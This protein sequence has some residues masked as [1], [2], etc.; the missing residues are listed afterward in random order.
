MS[1]KLCRVQPLLLILL[2]GVTWVSSTPDVGGLNLNT[3]HILGGDR[4]RDV[5]R[6]E[7]DRGLPCARI[8][9]IDA[10][11]DQA[12]ADLGVAHETLRRTD[13]ATRDRECTQEE[14]EAE[15]VRK[16]KEAEIAKAVAEEAAKK[17]AAGR[18]FGKKGKSRSCKGWRRRLRRCRKMMKA[19]DADGETPEEG[20]APD[21]AAPAS[22]KGKG[23][24][25]GGKK[26]KKGDAEA[27]EAGADAGAENAAA[28]AGEAAAAGAAADENAE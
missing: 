1:P 20:D 2:L 14:M 7:T 28:N 19:A 6:N 17:A 3:D 25:K 12:V 16:A 15:K 5:A 10:D 22:K 27:S 13:I 23:G 8:A 21:G 9:G 4:D 26:N 11:T 24:K 18:G